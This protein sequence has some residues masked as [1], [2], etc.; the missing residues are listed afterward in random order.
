MFEGSAHP[1]L[2]R[3]AR[4]APFAA[5][6]FCHGIL[7]YLKLLPSRIERW[8]QCRNFTI[9]HLQTASRCFILLVVRQGPD[10]VNRNKRGAMRNG[11]CGLIDATSSPIGA[12]LNTGK[13]V[14][15]PPPDKD[16]NVVCD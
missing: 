1:S 9:F 13:I 4:I 6:P 3:D 2:T 16:T 5:R 15:I 14:L 8:H 12:V 7:G 10:G 11:N